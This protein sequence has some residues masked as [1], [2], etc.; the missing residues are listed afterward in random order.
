MHTVELGYRDV[1]VWSNE[2]I[3]SRYANIGAFLQ[4]ALRQQSVPATDVQY[5][6]TSRHHLGE[7]S[8]E[9]FHAPLMHEA[10]MNM[11]KNTH[12]AAPTRCGREQRPPRIEARLNGR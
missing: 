12:V 5:P 7:G 2:D 11:T 1:R 10:F 9:D 8:R 3:H 4:N 6:R